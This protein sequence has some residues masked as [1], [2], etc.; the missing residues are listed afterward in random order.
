MEEESILKDKLEELEQNKSRFETQVAQIK[1]EILSSEP[2][3]ENEISSAKNKALLIFTSKRDSKINKIDKALEDKYKELEALVD[4]FSDIPEKDIAGKIELKDICD[5][6]KLVYPAELVDTYKGDLLEY[7]SDNEA[8]EDYQVLERAT[9]NLTSDSFS[10]KLFTKMSDVLTSIV[11]ASDGDADGDDGGV[12]ENKSEIKI[13]L[14][15]GSSL[16]LTILFAPFIAVNIF[17]FLSIAAYFRGIQMKNSLTRLHSIREYISDK[18]DYDIFKEDKQT[19][20]SNVKEF[21]DEVKEEYHELVLSKEFEFDKTVEDN[22]RKKYEDDIVNSKNRI[23]ALKENIKTLDTEITEVKKKLEQVLE[24]KKNKAA[25]IKLD[26][27]SV[28]NPQSKWFD[29]ILLDIK[30]DDEMDLT[31]NHKSNTLYY[32]SNIDVLQEFNRLYVLQ[33]II[34]SNPNFL[35]TAVFDYK[36]MCSSLLQFKGLPQSS[37]RLCFTNE[38]IEERL[39]AINDDVQ[40]R[41]TNILGA[42]KNIE[43]FN[44]LMLDYGATGETYWL[45]HIF[46]VSRFDDNL[47]FLLRNG[48]KVGYFFKIYLTESEL[49]KDLPFDCFQN[50]YQ[51]TDTV[52]PMKLDDLPI[53]S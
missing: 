7:D 34:H 39:K 27:L 16:I 43:D 51:V 37:C 30:N 5:K 53:N 31:D 38:D 9:L 10:A 48:P 13:A 6:L 46:G 11:E 29:K 45:I 3:I 21:L 44:K 17:T 23:D 32:A 36:Y 12:K 15:I 35:S 14:S 20:M 8:F 26:F 41:A 25:K 1:K 22:I 50:L 24:E 49:E 33:T 18:H 42:C 4:T 19:I 28:V 47:I 2:L 52:I 40:L